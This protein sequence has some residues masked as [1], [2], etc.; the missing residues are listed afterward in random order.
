MKNESYKGRAQLYDVGPA[1]GIYEVDY[2]IST[3]VQRY[4]EVGG[5]SIVREVF[6]A[7]IRSVSGYL[8][9][10]GFYELKK[11]NGEVHKLRK[12]GAAWE[13]LTNQN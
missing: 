7:D 6:S 9:K 1:A 13:L 10:N 11:H 2:I 4:K 8:L 12:A 5:P 3:S